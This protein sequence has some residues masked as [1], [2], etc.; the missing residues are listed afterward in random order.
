M[1]GGGKNVTIGTQSTSMI[2]IRDV[3]DYAKNLRNL[4]GKSTSEERMQ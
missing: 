1:F 4:D 3:M 2:E